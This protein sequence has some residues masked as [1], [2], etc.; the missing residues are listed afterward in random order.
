MRFQILN[1]LV[2]RMRISPAGGLPRIN[3]STVSEL[4]EAVES[5]K[6]RAFLAL[7][8][9]R[10]HMSVGRQ[11]RTY[12][13]HDTKQPPS[14]TQAPAPT[15]YRRYSSDDTHLGQDNN[16]ICEPRRRDRVASYVPQHRRALRQRL[17]LY[18]AHDDWA[19]RG[20]SSPALAHSPCNPDRLEAELCQP[21]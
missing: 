18:R 11:P 8:F 6:S 7:Y 1:R 17:G 12:A 15:A 21:S 5:W 4:I 20:D 16:R 14:G 19:M 10:I 13:N 3:C 9:S 2:F